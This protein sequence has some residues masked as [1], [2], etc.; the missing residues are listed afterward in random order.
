VFKVYSHCSTSRSSLTSELRPSF[1]VSWSFMDWSRADKEKTRAANATNRRKRVSAGKLL[2][3][4]DWKCKHCS[5][6]FSKKRNGPANHMRRCESTQAFLRR[7]AKPRSILDSTGSSTSSLTSSESSN[8][9]SVESSSASDSESAEN[10]ADS[11]HEGFT[12][13]RTRRAKARQPVNDCANDCML[14]CQTFEWLT[15]SSML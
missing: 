3:S 4:L 2:T 10:S 5:R 13:G 8:S 12:R 9:E 7:A 15:N 1:T 6:W 14:T 11:G